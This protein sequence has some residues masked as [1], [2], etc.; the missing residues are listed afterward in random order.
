MTTTDSYQNH[1]RMLDEIKRVIQSLKSH[2]HTMEQRY[3]QQIDA[4]EAAGFMQAYTS[5][6]R[7]MQ[8]RF[9]TK[10]EHLTQLIEKHE[11]Q[12]E[13]QKEVIQRFR[14]AARNNAL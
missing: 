11:M 13:Q 5:Q 8:Q 6:L 7:I 1:L 4:S 3:K 12:L 14:D 2:L 9:H 10:I